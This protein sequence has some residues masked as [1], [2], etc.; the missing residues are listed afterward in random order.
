MRVPSRRQLNKPRPFSPTDEHIESALPHSWL[1]P[2]AKDLEAR[3]TELIKEHKVPGATLGILQD[4]EITEVAAGVINL[5]TGVEATT[6]T[7][8]Q[9]GS[10]T[11][12]WTATVVMQLVDEGLLELDQPVRKYLPDFKVADPEVTEKVTVRDLLSHRSGI[13][14]D[15]FE[16]QGRGDDCL[17]LYVASCA[18]LKQTHP[19]GA[20][21]SYCNTGYSV[22][23]R[24]I[25]VLTG[26]VWDQAMKEKLF[27]PLDL[28]QTNTLPEE[29]LLFRTAVGHM[30]PKPGDPPQVAPIWMLP[31]VCGPM[32]LINSTVR[33]VL[34]WAQLHLEDGKELISSE[35]IREMRQPQIQIP[36][37]YTLG[38]NWGTGLIVFDWDGRRLYGHDGDTLGQHARLKFLPEQN[39][40]ITL[41][42]NGGQ[43]GQ[44]ER[45]LFTELF[46]DLAGIRVPSLPELPKT[47]PKLDLSRYAG[48][49]ERLL[50]RYDLAAENG[51]L[52]GTITVSPPK[53][54][55]ALAQEE[56]T[57][58]TLTPV[59]EQTFL[60]S[61]EHQEGPP[62][63]AV[64]Y[65]FEVGVPQYLHSGARANRRG[66]R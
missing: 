35:L 50:I 13:D 19:L 44:V 41:I 21:M 36:D 47:P 56:P 10:M 24:I 25:E 46:S 54:L 39:L 23:G 43:V 1:V 52:A 12:A 28:T 53:G 63:P 48:T 31:R 64:F 30:P 7:V 37:P 58:V 59:D 14:G 65:E 6:D 45:K 49:Y 11:K 32:G 22:S 2:N 33:D 60:A 57:K 26:K 3:L 15:N 62:T 42:M 27:A 51:K 55:E 5:N 38:S 8:W 61:T 66:A 20:T 16:D 17:E 18:D 34:T 4:G 40:A 29:A 9:I